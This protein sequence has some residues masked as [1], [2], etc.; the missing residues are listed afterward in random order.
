MHRHE[1][2]R[3]NLAHR[4]RALIPIHGNLDLRS[5]RRLKVRGAEVQQR[6]CDVELVADLPQ[7][8][9]VDGV[10][11]E[12]DGVG[13]AVGGAAVGMLHQEAGA[14]D[15]GEVLAG[16]GGD[17]EGLPG[18]VEGDGFPRTEA[19]HAWPWCQVLG[20]VD[21]GEDGAAVEEGAAVV[22]EV[23]DVV[24]VAQEDGV[25]WR[26]LVERQGGV[27]GDGEFDEAEIPGAAGG[28]EEGVG[29]EVDAVEF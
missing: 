9:G 1:P 5:P 29:E 2:I 26:E 23:V 12:P 27:V 24:F 10:T 3:A 15:A 8:G 11:G 4:L 22:V 20:A 28:G 25:D 19:A 6:G 14:L 18:D 16:S 17:M 13:E 7:L 21:G